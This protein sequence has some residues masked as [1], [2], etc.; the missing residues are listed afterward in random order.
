[1]AVSYQAW[2]FGVNVANA[3]LWQSAVEIRLSECVK[4]RRYETSLKSI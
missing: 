2:P 1:M 4:Q 3:A